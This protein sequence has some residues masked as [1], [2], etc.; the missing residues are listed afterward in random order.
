LNLRNRDFA[1]RADDDW[2][3]CSGSLRSHSARLLSN[4]VTIEIEIL[5]AKTA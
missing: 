1:A 3:R 5:E 2:R 4:Q